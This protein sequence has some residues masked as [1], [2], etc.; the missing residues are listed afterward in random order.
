MKYSLKKAKITDKSLI[1]N[2]LQAYLRELNQY[3]DIPQKESGRYDYPYLD[4]YWS[5]DDRFPY[6]MY[7]DKNVAGFALVR[8]DMDYYE[9]AEFC[10]LPDYRRQGAG[11][12]LAS[13]IIRRHPG[14]WHIEYN[15]NNI[16]GFRFWNKLVN[17][18]A[19]KNYEKRTV[20]GNRECL[21]FVIDGI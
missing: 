11:N 15:L 20:E 5:D 14:R 17:R 13:Q 1:D 10:I 6:L 3:E 12:I 19:G 8:K 7:L 18:L 21:E 9:M 16:A 4:Y 2:L